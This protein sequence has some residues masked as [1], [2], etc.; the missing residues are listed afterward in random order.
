MSDD[1]AVLCLVDAVE[2]LRRLADLRGW[3][4]RQL[5]EDDDEGPHPKAKLLKSLDG[6][7][8]AILGE[9]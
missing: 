9:V 1:E 8:K 4:A 7:Q 3:A 5:P 6:A 2:N